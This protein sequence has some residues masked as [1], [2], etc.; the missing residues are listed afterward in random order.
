[1]KS[2]K[3]LIIS[4]L[5]ISVI[6]ASAQQR[7]FSDWDAT[8]FCSYTRYHPF[9]YIRADNNWDILQ[10]LRN[11]HPRHYLDSLGI[12]NTE[13]QI[14]LLS[15]E[16]FVQQKENGDWQSVIPIFDSIQT[17]EAR[18]LSLNIASDLYKTIKSDCSFFA[19]F[20][21][22]EKLQDNAYSILFSY[23]LDGEIWNYFNSYE[24]LKSAATWN[25]MCWFFYSPRSFRS[26]TN[27]FNNEFHLC[28][29]ENQPDFISKELNSSDFVIPFLEEFKKYE[30]IVSE[31]LKLKAISLGMIHENG[32]LNIPV[33]DRADK[34]SQLNIISDRIIK[35]IVDYF[36]DSGIIDSFQDKF[37]VSHKKLACTILYHEVM[38]DLM[39]LLL[40]DKIIE[41]PVVWKSQNKR[42]TYS[43]IY[44]E[45]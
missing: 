12:K 15:I 19:D 23:I 2:K 26:G 21:S 28:W 9:K 25:G 33:I 17:L 29:T 30:K 42:D 39:D 20:L 36:T 43:V 8:A 16:G 6:S 22:N 38:W 44:I 27:Q 37:G 10:A 3:I 11:P 45:K 5:F 18:T 41:L 13:S 40:G 32:T 34:D 35:A 7:P 14:M 24:E 4:F 1:M 31:D